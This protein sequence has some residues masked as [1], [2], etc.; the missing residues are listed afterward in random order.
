MN[1][2]LRSFLNAHKT[3]IV[4]VLFLVLF[5]F[6]VSSA[7]PLYN[8][9]Q[10]LD[11]QCAPGSTD[12][13][14]SIS[15]WKAVTG[16]I[17][18]SEG[19]VGI[20]ITTTP[21]A[22]LE[23]GGGGTF[24]ASGTGSL[25]DL[26]AG[27]RMAWSPS[28]AAFRAGSVSG[29]QWDSANV[30]Y[31]SVAFGE[32]NIASGEASTAFGVGNTAS[33][34]GATA[35]GNVTTASGDRSTAFGYSSIASAV[36]STA[37]GAATT[38]SGVFSTAFG[39]VSTASSSFS[40]AFGYST[41]AS[42][43]SSTA[44]GNTTTASAAY[45]TAL[46]AFNIGGGNPITWVST[47][48]LFEIG[49]GIDASHKSDA[50]MILKNGNVGVGTTAPGGVLTVAGSRTAAAWGLNGIN[51]QTAAATYTDSSTP[52]VTTVASNMVNSFGIPTLAS[53]NNTVTYTSAA[54]VYIA[55]AP[56]AGTNVTLTNKAALVVA[57][58]N[59]GIGT[60]TPRTLLNTYQ[61]SGG[62]MIKLDNDGVGSGRTSDI[63]FGYDSFP[64]RV[65]AKIGSY[66]YPG[67]N[68]ALAFYTTAD[69][70]LTSP[71][72]MR[73]DYN[74]NIGIGTT[75]PSGLL[76]LA[77]NK[78][79]AAWGTSG[80]NFQ[81]AAATYTD[82]S[83]ATGTV[84]NNMVNSFGIPTL[85]AANTGVTYSNAATVYIAGAPVAGTNTAITNPYA[86]Y[87][88]GGNSNFGGNINASGSGSFG[89]PVAITGN[90]NSWYGLTITNSNNT[91]NAG[92]GPTLRLNN[93]STSYAQFSKAAST[94]TSW[95]II[96]ANDAFLLNDLTGNIDII[97]TAGTIRFGTSVST[98]TPAL[99]I[100]TNGTINAGADYSASY[101][102]NSYVQ[103]SYVT[104]NYV[105]YTGATSNINLNSQ[106]LT[107]AGQLA[108]V[109]VVHA[110]TGT[111][112][113]TI[114]GNGG[115][116]FPNVGQSA[117][118][119][120]IQI[121]NGTGTNYIWSATMSGT[122]QLLY[123]SPA[124]H[125][126]FV[127]GTTQAL[128]ISPTGINVSSLLAL[129]GNR[130]SLSWGVDGVNFQTAAATYQD[131]GSAAAATIPVRVANSFGTPT[132]SS[133]NAITVTSA[134][135]VY[136]AGA[137]VAGAN[138]T[139]ANSAALVV[140]SGKVG[141]SN[142]TPGYLLHVGNNTASGI[143][144]RFENSTGTCDISPTS[145]AL[146][147]SSDMTRKKN[148]ALL[149]DGSAWS[150]SGNIAAGSQTVLGRILAL[151][152]VSYNWNSEPDAAPRHPGF[153]AQ[154]VRQLF[155]DLVAV[156]PKTGLLSM[157][158]T[159]LIPYTVSAIQEMNLNIMNIGDLTKT[160]TWR[161]SLIAWLGSASNG[162]K[163]LVVHDKI[164]VDDECLTKNDIH[165]LLQM[166]QQNNGGSAIVV[167]PPPIEQAGSDTGTQTPEVQP[168]GEPQTPITEQP[169]ADP[170][171]GTPSTGL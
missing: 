160:N 150:F 123:S 149:A 38:A 33:Q 104:G 61:A 8:P 63:E 98:V 73:I 7:A 116:T 111:T 125:I 6:A 136:I 119:G 102:A 126:F 107:N 29:T 48:P 24:L 138:T 82:S 109:S 101:T 19:N 121:V 49:N 11:P 164:C 157:N 83:S 170:A 113:E 133:S 97:N 46:G 35:F 17:N 26:G 36:F 27:T 14:V 76:T 64:T 132:F 92:N 146:V 161:D 152:P 158:Y 67:G 71:E 96:G 66:L 115:S 50:L 31:S 85:A 34:F 51:F 139:I 62:T 122:N 72:R 2:S 118:F 10:T 140:A 78:S 93:D 159:G 162:I 22:A 44:F 120:S 165:Q 74:G 41:I 53:T 84:T 129:A 28:L 16:G 45:S 143:V 80:V 88:A 58:G 169:P 95:N 1:R 47:D 90:S 91:V 117:S 70:G 79:A 171:P 108:A 124:S 147:C 40:T 20:G 153:I 137:P 25:A 163:S 142:T 103:K 65:Y 155:P 9:G 54:S 168:I 166:K 130:S 100:N 52:A 154:D 55:G 15:P 30:G 5:S 110:S 39:A 128:A 32:N 156:D 99:T 105:P 86:L 4:S 77:G 43:G 23:I 106:N 114:I 167:T 12:C 68:T 59:V 57:S 89:G 112:S 60:L 21:R 127:N 148:I 56:V 144:A 94:F 42:G 87:V 37:F 75:A 145:T 134:A 131:T 18:Y 3:L 135:T 151:A 69:S 141:L 81:A 13:T